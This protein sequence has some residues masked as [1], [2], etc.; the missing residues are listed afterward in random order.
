MT[1]INDNNDSKEEIKRIYNL[2]NNINTKQQK[3]ERNFKSLFDD[4]KYL[5][6]TELKKGLVQLLNDL[7]NESSIITNNDKRYLYVLNYKLQQ[8]EGLLKR[9]KNVVSK[10]NDVQIDNEFF[11]EKNELNT[12][13]SAKQFITKED[14]DF[15]KELKKAQAQADVAKIDN[16]RLNKGVKGGTNP[17]QN[18]NINDYIESKKKIQETQKKLDTAKKELKKATK[19]LENVKKKSPTNVE[20]LT[21]AEE[22]KLEETQKVSELNKKLNEQ[23]LKE[24]EANTKLNDEYEKM[25]QDDISSE[26]NKNNSINELTQKEIDEK[27]I[28]VEKRNKNA[29]ELLSSLNKQKELNELNIGPSHTLDDKL[30]DIKYNLISIIEYST[31][32]LLEIDDF[33]Q[34]N[35]YETYVKK[36]KEYI[37]KNNKGKF[38][39]SKKE[40]IDKTLV[41]KKYS[42][43]QYFMNFNKNNGFEYNSIKKFYENNP[44]RF[45]LNVEY[46]DNCLDRFLEYQDNFINNWE[47]KGFSN[48]NFYYILSYY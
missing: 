26:Y 31:K 47:M 17:T 22:K 38:D 48:I 29:S 19:E 43:N 41:V 28:T 1:D 20:K 16:E 30:K 5:D 14:K 32:N 34:N 21:K 13:V 39:L 23:I 27:K 10:N 3:I 36:F 11:N 7:I 45:T 8:E 18:N 25:L 40:D 4:K 12:A 24:K 9:L 37:E 42:I 35:Y 33:L 46:Y 44:E 2:V 15:D 6:N